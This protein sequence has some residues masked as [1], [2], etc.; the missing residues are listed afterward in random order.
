MKHPVQIRASDDLGNIAYIHRDEGGRFRCTLA[1]GIPAAFSYAGIADDEMACRFAIDDC[2]SRETALAVVKRFGSP[3]YRYEL[4]PPIHIEPTEPI[5]ALSA[6]EA[7]VQR[8]KAMIPAV[9]EQVDNRPLDRARAVLAGY[10]AKTGL[11]SVSPMRP[12][13]DSTDDMAESSSP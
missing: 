1:N 12:S 4:I 10:S 2:D 8:L 13:V 3:N 11:A 9:F 6:L 7:E 5:A